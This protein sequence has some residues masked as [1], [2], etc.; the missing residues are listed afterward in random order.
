MTNMRL[1]WLFIISSSAGDNDIN[2]L[3]ATIT[4]EG[5]RLS[6]G[7]DKLVDRCDYSKANA[8]VLNVIQESLDLQVLLCWYYQP[9]S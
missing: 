8:D 1:V 7:I 5:S 3:V 2:T 6:A 4:S 9:N